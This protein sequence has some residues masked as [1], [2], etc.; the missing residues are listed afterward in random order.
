MSGRQRALL[1]LAGTNCLW[2]GS[3]V[4]GKAALAD[5]PF[6]SVNMLRFTIAAALLLPVLWRGR[7]QLPSARG[8]RWRLL[9]MCGLGFGGN[10]ALEYWGLSL[11]SATDTALLIAAEALAT[12]LLS[13]ALLSERIRALEA[14]GLLLGGLGVY[15]VVEGGLRAPTGLS[16]S[17]SLGNL[18]VVASLVLE[19]GFTVIGKTVVDRY[20]PLLITAAVVSGSLVAWWPAGLASL[21]LAGWP[22]LSLAGWLGIVYLGAITTALCYWGWL[23]GLKRVMPGAVAPLLFIQPL[24]GTALAVW[25]RGERPSWATLLGGGLILLGVTTVVTRRDPAPEAP[26]ATAGTA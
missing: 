8:D 25:I 13:V 26:A 10:K 14:L 21:R 7:H 22:P 15:L 2:A 6:A 19:A 4:A 12:V 18:L 3:Y 24:L 16:G 11:T 20:P 17:H 23:W 9:A 5:W 1:V